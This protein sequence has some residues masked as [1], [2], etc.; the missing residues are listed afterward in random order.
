MAENS[1]K[2]PELPDPPEKRC[3]QCAAWEPVGAIRGLCRRRAPRAAIGAAALWP[4]T[5]AMDWCFEHVERDDA[6]PL[7]PAAGAGPAL[8]QFAD[9]RGGNSRGKNHRR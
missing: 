7:F 3:D 6:P 9:Q 1:A 5:A 2:P 4:T 8:A